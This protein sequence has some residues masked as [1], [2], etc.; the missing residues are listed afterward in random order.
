MSTSDP[1]IQEL[2]TLRDWLRWGMSRL[3]EA[4]TCFGHG[5]DNAHD[6][7]LQLILHALHLPLDTPPTLLDARLTTAERERVLAL[8]RRRADERVPV[9]Y[10]TGT[11]WF[12]GL[13]FQVD[14]RVLIPRSP[15]AELIEAGFEPWLD[16]EP[17]RVLDLCTG[18]G[19]IGIACAYAFE[20]A[21][22]VLSDVS[23]EALT[24]ARANIDQHGLG[25]RVRA[26]ASDLFAQL[27]GERFDLIVSNPPYV[28]APDLAA[29]PPEYHHEPR[30]GL[31]AGEDGLDLARRILAEA[32]QHLNPG[33]LLVVEVG[34]SAPALETAFPHLPLT[35]IEFSRG[36][37]GVFAI[38]REQLLGEA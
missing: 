26:V 10:L 35:W 9:P 30:L 34:N 27:Q 38:T 33:G 31:A 32:P 29:M 22:V 23:G 3:T 36:G 21:E 11:A 28:D 7:A 24:V 12:A 16:E 19:C 5:T 4:G 37:E 13:P 20:G 25:E 8:L 17:A 15:I 2:F 14:A 18:S 6:E 1:L